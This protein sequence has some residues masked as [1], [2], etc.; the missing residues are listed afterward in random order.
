MKKTLIAL[1]TAATIAVTAIA[2]P[3]RAEARDG[4]WIPGAIF[5]GLA[6]GALAASAAYGPYYG[7]RYYYGP[8]PYWGGWGPAYA[9][10]PGPYYYGPRYYDG[11]RYYRS[12]AYYPRRHYYY[13]H[14]YYRH[15]HY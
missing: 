9:Y 6:L 1:A 5:G 12:Y 3:T 7:P 2:A 14:H 11:P 10:A 8:G 15:R 4:W 13:R